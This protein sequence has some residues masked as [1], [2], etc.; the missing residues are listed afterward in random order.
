MS[1][2]TLLCLVRMAADETVSNTQA[3]LKKIQTVKFYLGPGQ[4]Y[5]LHL[6]EQTLMAQ[7]LLKQERTIFKL[8]K[9]LLDPPE[10]SFKEKK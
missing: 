6:V 8:P 7:K 9:G 3:R 2:H 4:F 10:I 5:C 1:R